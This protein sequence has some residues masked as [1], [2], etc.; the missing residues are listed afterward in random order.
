MKSKFIFPTMVL[1]LS[2][3]LFSACS[4]DESSTGASSEGNGVEE[5]TDAPK[6]SLRVEI[7]N[8]I[9]GNPTTAVEDFD[10]YDYFGAE[11]TGLEHFTYGRFEAKMKMVSIS[12]SVSS[13]FLYYDDSWKK[14]DEPW[15]EIDIEVLGKNPGE[16]QSNL[17]TREPD[18]EDGSKMENQTSEFVTGFG[19]DATKDFHVYVME[20]TPEYISWEIDGK[21][22]RRDVTGMTTK[23]KH[24]QVAY[25]TKKQSLRFNLWASKTP[26]WTGKFTGAELKDGPVAQVIDYVKVSTYDPETKQFTE[27][28]T[29]EFDG[30]TLDSKRW[31]TGNWEME[32]VMLSKSNVV[33]EDGVCKLLISR[34]KKAE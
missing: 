5:E 18:G 15:N 11:L 29:D 6:D 31:S 10:Q 20:W 30:A 28:W 34:E 14:G 16:W 23:L 22:I 7:K 8:E 25:M 12:G 19:F 17:I 4:D 9:A 27:A 32:N 1:G 2:M 33:V 3:A 13:M 26:A 24:D 21:V